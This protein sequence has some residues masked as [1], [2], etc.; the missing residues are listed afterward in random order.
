MLS[1]MQ[2]SLIKYTEYNKTQKIHV[3]GLKTYNNMNT[4]CEAV[5]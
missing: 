1:K 4:D 2:I 5:L 3:Y